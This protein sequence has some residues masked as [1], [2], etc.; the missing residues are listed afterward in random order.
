M[1]F[2][3]IMMLAFIACFTF[4]AHAAQ[5]RC[6]D[7]GKEIYQN[8]HVENINLGENFLYFE[9]IGTNKTVVIFSDCVVRDDKLRSKRHAV[10][11][12]KK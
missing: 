6:Y 10:N 3:S 12:I 1:R 4:K 9:E 5:I 11:K 7:G 2:N 8:M